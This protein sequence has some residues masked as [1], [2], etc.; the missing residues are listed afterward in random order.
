MHPIQQQ[1]DKNEKKKLPKQI[2]K[3]VDNKKIP[4]TER[5]NQK[6]QEKILPQDQKEKSL[7]IQSSRLRNQPRKNHKTFIPQSKILKKVEFQKPL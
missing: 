6:I 5:K 7:Y 2:S 3:N 1:L 4:Q